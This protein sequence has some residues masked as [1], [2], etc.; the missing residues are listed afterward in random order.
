MFMLELLGDKITHRTTTTG[1]YN[2]VGKGKT[3]GCFAAGGQTNQFL[4][5]KVALICFPMFGHCGSFSI[6]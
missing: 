2:I 1:A 4:Q 5:L 6:R 3:E